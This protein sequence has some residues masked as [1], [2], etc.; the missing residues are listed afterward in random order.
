MGGLVCFRASCVSRC[1]LRPKIFPTLTVAVC[2]KAVET[3]VSVTW[4]FKN[5]GIFCAEGFGMIRLPWAGDKIHGR[6]AVCTRCIMSCTKDGDASISKPRYEIA[7]GQLHVADGF[8]RVS[9]LC[10]S[11]FTAQC[12]NLLD[13]DGRKHISVDSA[14]EGC[15]QLH[16][17]AVSELPP[18]AGV[19]K[20]RLRGLTR[21]ADD[22]VEDGQSGKKIVIVFESDFDF[23]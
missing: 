21:R 5:G 2:V 23:G 1:Y 11:M 19:A 9:F 10:R 22:G 8:G 16:N 14:S 20:Y 18:S 7:G 17:I 6:G 13:S 12:D 3:P 15:I 4:I